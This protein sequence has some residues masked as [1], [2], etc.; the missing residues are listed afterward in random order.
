MQ[1]VD[2][3][4]HIHEPGYKLDT[5]EVEKNAAKDG[6]TRFICVGTDVITS[7]QA[8]EFV[9]N[10][11][12]AWAS[13]GLHPHDA[14]SE[15]SISDLGEIVA[16]AK[17][18]APNKIVAIGECG[19]DYFYE[20]SPKAD[21]IRILRQQIELAQKYNLPIIFH[22]REAFDDFWPIFDSYKGL[23]GVLH[24]FTDNQANLDK[25]IERGLFIGVNGIA[26]F[27]KDPN[28][29]QVYK[30]IPL[31]KMLLETDAPFLTPNPFRGTVN[32][33]AKVKVV[34]EFLAKLR[35]ESIQ[36]IADSTTKNAQNLFS[37]TK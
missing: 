17:H 6:V 15:D 26:T 28:Q 20:N 32:E 27:A 37:L 16:I 30:N 4:C 11:P 31:G 29:L 7:R 25:A 14:K 1:F 18:V 2:T 24:S 8:V 36:Q 12:N 5:S 22:V 10:R 34:A 19:L 3:H 9:K 13:V 35:G 23:R 21:Q 33:P